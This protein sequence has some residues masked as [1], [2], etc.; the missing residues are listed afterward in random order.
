MD[1]P[2]EVWVLV[3]YTK[4][5]YLFFVCKYEQ[6][7]YFIYTQELEIVSHSKNRGS[8]DSNDYHML[9]TSVFYGTG[10]FLVR[11]TIIIVLSVGLFITLHRNKDYLE[12]LVI[13]QYYIQN[14]IHSALNAEQ[15]V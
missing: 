8:L 11:N 4:F 1:L 12:I 9:I 5:I 3:L 10:V 14:D 7:T 13:K 6:E 2:L 15:N